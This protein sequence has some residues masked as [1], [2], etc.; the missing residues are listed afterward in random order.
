MASIVKLLSTQSKNVCRTHHFRSL[1]RYL[2]KWK[3]TCSVFC[4]SWV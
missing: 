1:S 3:Q 4:G 2:R